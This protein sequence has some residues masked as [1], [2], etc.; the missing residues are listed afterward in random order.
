MKISDDDFLILQAIHRCSVLDYPCPAETVT[1]A[2]GLIEAGLVTMK[3][4]VAKNGMADLFVTDDA[5]W[6]LLAGGRKLKS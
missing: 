5:K 3:G 6:K 2:A 4:E 1:K